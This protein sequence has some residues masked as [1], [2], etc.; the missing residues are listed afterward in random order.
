FKWSISVGTITEGQGTDQITVDTSWL[1]GQAVTATVELV[2]A[3]PGCKSSASTITEVKPPPMVCGLAFDE[4]GDIKFEDEKARLDNFAIQL[5][6]IPE[7]S[8]LIHMSAGQKTFKG[9]AAYRLARARSY[10]VH[11]RGIDSRRIITVDCG[12]TQEL[13]ASLIIVPPGA[14]VPECETTG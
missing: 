6:N 12:F 11:V 10:L 1:G 5:A 3:P 7:S 13:I 9:E 4:Y 8:G 14:T 2:G